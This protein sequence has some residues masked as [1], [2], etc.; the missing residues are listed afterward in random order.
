MPRQ[1][2]VGPLYVGANHPRVL[3]YPFSFAM[4]SSRDYDFEGVLAVLSKRFVEWLNGKIQSGHARSSLKIK[5]LFPPFGSRN[6]FQKN[7]VCVFKHMLS[8]AVFSR[9]LLL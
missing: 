3:Q 7:W 5:L 9:I 1:S 6:T 8:R 2:I 4:H